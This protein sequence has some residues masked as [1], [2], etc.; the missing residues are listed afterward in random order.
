MEGTVK[1]FNRKKGFGFIVGED[2]QDYFVHYTAVPRGVFLKENDRVSF[3][4]VET[5]KGK[6]AQNVTLAEGGSQAA[7]VEQAPT[8]EET[9][10]EEAPVQEETSAE[11]PQEEA[12]AKPE[13]AP[14]EEEKT[15]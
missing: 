15:E 12:E 3:E 4:A 2:G 7:P 13:E 5:D 6:Q 1:W 10:P 11:E 8:Q 14:V 9:T